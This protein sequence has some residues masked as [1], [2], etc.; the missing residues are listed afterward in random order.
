MSPRLDT[1]RARLRDPSWMAGG[2]GAQ[3][4]AWAV[5]SRHR[6]LER[7]APWPAR[8]AGTFPLDLGVE[9][10]DLDLLVEV[11]DLDA[12][13]ATLD[14]VFGADSNYARVHGTFTDGPAEVASFTLDGLTV[15]IF[16]Q[17]WPVERQMGWLH[18]LAEARLLH[19][20]PDAAE[21]L[22]ALKRSGLKTEPAFACLFGLCGDPY[23]ALA[24]LAEA[25]DDLLDSIAAEPFQ[26]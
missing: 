1:I 11:T 25:P 20:R 17:A 5:L 23:A 19:A 26:P 7:L 24:A 2:S 15:E 21:P 18:L 14:Q 12:A 4:Q 13:A 3:R 6:L 10:S 22:R 16:A 8:L 9:G